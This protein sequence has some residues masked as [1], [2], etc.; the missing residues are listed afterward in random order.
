MKKYILTGGPGVGKTKVLEAIAARGHHVIKEVA[1]I[2]IAQ[3]QEKEKT[4]PEYRAILPWTNLEQFQNVVLERQIQ[5]E[6]SLR[7]KKVS[8]SFLDR[9]CVDPL[10]YVKTG[11]VPIRKDIYHIIEQAEY[12]KAFFLHRLPS[13]AKDEQ[14]KEDDELALRLHDMMYEVY[15]RVGVDIVEVPIFVDNE[16][17]NIARRIDFILAHTQ[18]SART[19]I[20]KKYRVDH[21]RVRQALSEYHTRDSGVDEEWNRVYDIADLLT[22]YDC[23]LR[24]RTIG[25]EHMLTIKGPNQSTTIKK[26]FEL[27]LDLPSCVSSLAH[28]ILPQNVSYHKTRQTYTPVGDS[29]CKICLDYIPELGEEFVEIEAASEN[30]VLLWEKR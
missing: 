20:E 8:S 28:T 11:N 22:S 16:R 21:N 23:L 30:Q 1:R 19:E 15:D 2:I 27:N 26:R 7:G 13:Y 29:S 18:D 9:S 4:C 3:E 17:E 12:T 14:R 6:G 10:A 5:E 25:E 24:I